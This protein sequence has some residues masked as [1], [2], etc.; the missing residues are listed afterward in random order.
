MKTE[1]NTGTRTMNA[2]IADLTDLG[3]ALARDLEV[4]ASLV[5]GSTIYKASKADTNFCSTR[6]RRYYSDEDQDFNVQLDHG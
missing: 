6:P 4:Y 5:G 2:T 3:Q 1:L